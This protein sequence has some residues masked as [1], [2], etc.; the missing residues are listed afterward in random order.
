MHSRGNRFAKIFFVVMIA[1]C[2]LAGCGG[3]LFS[4]KGRKVTQKDLMVLL[5]DG[6][7]QGL[8]KNS[9]LVITYQYQ[10]TGETLK[11]DGTVELAGTNKYFNHLTVYLLF[12]DDQAVVVEDAL[13]YSAGN[14]RPVLLS[15]KSFGKTIP[16]PERARTISFAYD[17]TPVL[18]K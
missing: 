6:N 13:I 5:K 7:Q 16:I 3:T 8:W 17:L 11:L 15:S 10:M 18:V 2:Y 12:L 1:A 4:H 9:E 14:N